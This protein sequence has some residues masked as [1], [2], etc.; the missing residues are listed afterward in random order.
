MRKLV[1]SMAALAL[2]ACAPAVP[3]SGADGGVGFGDYDDYNAYRIARDDALSDRTQ[4]VPPP[5]QITTLPPQDAPGVR[6]AATPPAP[7]SDATPTGEGAEPPTRVITADNPRISDEQDFGAV[8][9][10]ESIESDAERLRAQRQAYQVIEPTAVPSRSGNAEPNVVQYAITTTNPVGQRLYRRSVLTS[11]KKHLAS[12]AKYASPDLAQEAFL[13][14]GGPDRD[15][16]GLD[17]DGDGFACTW[18]PT[19]YRRIAR[20]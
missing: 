11:S 6:A 7:D 12:C 15:K 16:L 13:R 19:Q 3:D 5:P 2:V 20:G 8:S 18:D 1:V 14:A 4:T 9:D 17:P 10:R